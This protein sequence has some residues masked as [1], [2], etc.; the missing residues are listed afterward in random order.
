MHLNISFSGNNSTAH[1]KFILRLT[2]AFDKD[3][4]FSKSVG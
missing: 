2:L 4:N 1:Y 3:E